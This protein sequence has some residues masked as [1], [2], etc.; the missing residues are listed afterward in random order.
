MVKPEENL[1]INMD[2]FQLTESEE[3]CE[4]LL[5]VTLQPNLKW[6]KHA[7]ELQKKLKDRLTGLMKTRHIVTY[8]FRK[9]V[10]E[11]IFMSVLTYCIP[12]WGGLDQGDLQDLQVMQNKAAQIVLN[13]PPRSNRKMMYT[14]LSWLTVNQ[15]IFFH[16]V[17]AVS[18][19]TQRNTN[20]TVF[21]SLFV[22]NLI[23]TS[24]IILS[25]FII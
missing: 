5:G 14:S 7:Q 8:A 17:L 16:S 22:F 12:A 4:K 23:I 6:T 25:W 1:N 2:G 3:K 9:T 13:L 19:I 21:N 20:R 15:L 11:G 18:K 24:F 10:A